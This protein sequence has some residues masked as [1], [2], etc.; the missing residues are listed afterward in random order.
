MIIRNSRIP[1]ILSL[2]MPIVAITIWPFIFIAP[3]R[4]SE[5]IIR[6]EKIHL[7][8]CKELFVIGFYVLYFWDFFVGLIKYKNIAPAYRAIRFEQEAVN[9]A[10]M[11]FDI[12]KRKA[13]AWREYK[14]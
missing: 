1:K 10:T 13:Y 4:D 7:A 9:L 14:I 11:A 3:G 12:N 8:Q 6:H 5:E 2:F